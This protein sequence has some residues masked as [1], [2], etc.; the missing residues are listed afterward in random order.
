MGALLQLLHQAFLHSHPP[1][2]D[3]V[4]EQHIVCGCCSE[5]HVDE[6]AREQ[7]RQDLRQHDPGGVG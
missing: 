4:A 6:I 2:S 3:E 7:E 5:I 1:D